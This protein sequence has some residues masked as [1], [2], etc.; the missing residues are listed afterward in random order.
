MTPDCRAS[1]ALGRTGSRRGRI[2]P[3]ASDVTGNDRLGGGLFPLWLQILPFVRLLCWLCCH[4]GATALAALL[5]QLQTLVVQAEPRVPC[6]V[7]LQEL[8][9]K[10]LWQS[11]VS[12]LIAAQVDAL[13]T[14][15]DTW[16]VPTEAIGNLRSKKQTH[17]DLRQL[18]DLWKGADAVG[19]GGQRVQALAA[20]DGGGDGL[21]LV[22]AQVQLLQLLQ[23]S[24]FAAAGGDVIKLVYVR[25]EEPGSRTGCMHPSAAAPLPA[26][27]TL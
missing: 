27:G 8:R 5:Q 22:A 6:E 14:G 10:R 11:R 15:Q 21:Q 4:S 12:Q 13:W 20:E 3:E 24:Q 23:S 1:V 2:H 17:L 16:S 26:S 19:M 7:Q 18:E 25:G 9:R